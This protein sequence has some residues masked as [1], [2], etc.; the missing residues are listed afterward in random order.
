[1]RVPRRRRILA[2]ILMTSS[3]VIVVKQLRH[4]DVTEVTAK[5]KNPAA[6]KPSR[7]AVEQAPGQWIQKSSPSP[8]TTVTSSEPCDQSE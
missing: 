4:R 6:A 3:L 2:A 8:T 1:M 5:V 7:L